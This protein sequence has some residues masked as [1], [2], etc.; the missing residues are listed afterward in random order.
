MSASVSFAFAAGLLATVNPCGF[1][2]LPSFLSFYLGANEE[3]I[4]RDSVAARMRQGL[5]VGVV[6]S[7]AFGGVFVFAGLV[8]S[9]GMRAF[10]QLVPWLAVAIGAA[11]LVLG[12]AMLAGRHIGLTAAS[13]VRVAAQGER[14]YGRVALFGVTYALASLS[15]TLAIFLVVVG[16]ALAVSDPIQLLAVFGAYAAGSA[17]I[18]IALSL[19]AALAK[20][21]LARAVRRLVPVVNRVAGALLAASG[22]YLL[23]YWVPNLGGGPVSDSRMARA[24]KGISSTLAGF[25]AGNVRVFALVLGALALLGAALL[26]LEARRKTAATDADVRR[27]G[28][29]VDQPREEPATVGAGERGGTSGRLENE[30]LATAAASRQAAPTR[31]RHKE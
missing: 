1:A 31:G 14:S 7:A 21:A 2:L 20:A 26:L 29:L 9:A 6:L 22:T 27:I 25:F 16:Q 18:L 4:E 17:S 5:L 3:G 19:S 30:P 28:R 10:I 23:L 11:L 24:S 8:V 12:L 13:R 15:C